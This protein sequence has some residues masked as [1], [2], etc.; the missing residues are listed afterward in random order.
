MGKYIPNIS[1]YCAGTNLKKG[2]EV[3]LTDDQV[4]ALGKSVT[5]SKGTLEDKM[6]KQAANKG[7]KKKEEPKEEGE[8]KEGEKKEG[9]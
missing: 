8:K 4:K 6:V 2:E 3:E 7:A 1:G 9:E 5:P